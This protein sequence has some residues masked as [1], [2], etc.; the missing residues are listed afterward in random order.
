[1]FMCVPVCSVVPAPGKAQGLNFRIISDTGTVKAQGNPYNSNQPP[2]GI[3]EAI[4]AMDIGDVFVMVLRNHGGNQRQQTEYEALERLGATE[5]RKWQPNYNGY[6]AMS[7]QDMQQNAGCESDVQPAHQRFAYA[8]IAMKTGEDS[9]G[10]SIGVTMDEAGGCNSQQVTVKATNCGVSPTT[11]RPPGYC[12]YVSAASKDA[13]TGCPGNNV[14]GWVGGGAQ[15]N[16]CDTSGADWQASCTTQSK[17]VACKAQCDACDDC[18]GYEMFSSPGEIRCTMKKNIVFDVAPSPFSAS[19]S[20]W[21]VNVNSRHAACDNGQHLHQDVFS[22]VL[23]LAV[24]VAAHHTPNC[25]CCPPQQSVAWHRSTAPHCCWQNQHYPTPF[26]AAV[27]W[28]CGVGMHMT[29]VACLGTGTEDTQAC[30]RNQC[31]CANGEAANGPAES[32][33]DTDCLVH[34]AETCVACNAGYYLGTESTELAGECN[35]KHCCLKVCE[36]SG[37]TAVAAADC[38]GHGNIACLTCDADFFLSTFPSREGR[39]TPRRA[40][41]RRTTL[42]LAPPCPATSRHATP[43]H[44][45]LRHA[46]QRHATPLHPHPHHC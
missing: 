22:V 42:R 15:I 33:F 7:V 32:D 27:V 38:P 30:A 16:A 21:Q 46:K 8:I 35:A 34:G 13:A 23:A 1:M 31:T 20:G 12:G 5:F 41:L 28:K 18:E 9:S 4:Q 14:N 29:G 25:T 10:N 11:E 19:I 6:E 24:V 36:C 44:D 2:G 43:H 39:T 37:G 17:E 45:T 40:A 3:A 26:H